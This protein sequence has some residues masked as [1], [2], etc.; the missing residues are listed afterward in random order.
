MLYHQ[1]KD[2]LY[3]MRF[4]GHKNVNNTLLYVQLEEALFGKEPDEFVCKVAKTVGEATR[5]VEAGFD[6]VCDFDGLKI[7][8]KRR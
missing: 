2:I 4:L 7:F 5:L 3:V 1:T 8:R 6:Y